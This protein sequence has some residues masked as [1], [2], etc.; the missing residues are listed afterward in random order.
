MSSRPPVPV[1]PVE[2]DASEI[3]AI[4]RDYAEGWYTGNAERMDRALHTALVK[5]TALEE[6]PGTL[7]DVTKTRMLELTA[8]GG[9]GDPEADVEVFIDDV[10]ID[11]A[12][13]RVVSPEYL[14]YL[15]L[16]KT[17]SGW[18]IANVLF[19]DRS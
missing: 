10:S 7:R 6:D 11:I 5:R 16:V 4:A 14:D 1:P 12:T 9:G 8:D 2:S 15:H 3:E 19:R 18:K 17:P 13:V